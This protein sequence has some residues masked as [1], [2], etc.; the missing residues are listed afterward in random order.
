MA[1]KDYDLDQPMDALIDIAVRKFG[2][3]E[4][5]KVVVGD[6]SLE[7]LQIK[8]MQRY[9]DK[10]MDQTR[11]GKKIVLPLWAKVW[12]SCLILGY[13]LTQFPFKDGCRVLEVGAGSAINSLVLALRGIDVTVT[14][15]DPDALLFARINALKNGLDDKVVIS[16]TDF[17]MD[18]IAGPFDYIVGCEI[19][20]DEAVFAPLT[21]F[22]S[23]HLAK[24]DSAEVF[25]ALDQKRRAQKFFELAS[26][27]FGMMK[28]RAEYTD[29]KTGDK[30]IINLFR[31]KRK[32]A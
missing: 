10:L 18:S 28:S 27:R 11:S 3:V 16:R 24:E 31:L 23:E 29:E 32:Q 5:E 26:E 30:N 21:Q 8:N 15:V 13:T 9:I 20:Y 19:L 22:L 4:F 1:V 2:D 6:V 7:V 17:T 25:L 14:D 12:P